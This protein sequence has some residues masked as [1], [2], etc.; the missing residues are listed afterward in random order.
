MTNNNKFYQFIIP[1]KDSNLLKFLNNINIIYKDDEAVLCIKNEDFSLD[2]NDDGITFNSIIN[3]LQDDL[4]GV[5]KFD[6]NVEKA[7]DYSEIEIPLGLYYMLSL[8][9]L[10]SKIIH[11]HEKKIFLSLI[12]R[13]IEILKQSLINNT[14][15]SQINNLFNMIIFCITNIVLQE[16]DILEDLINQNIKLFENKFHT[17]NKKNSKSK[18]RKNPKYNYEIDNSDSSNETETELDNSDSFHDQL[19][20]TDFEVNLNDESIQSNKFIQDSSVLEISFLLVKY[21]IN[22][23]KHYLNVN[24]S[25]VGLSEWSL[26]L[27]LRIINLVK[28]LV[29]NF[30]IETFNKLCKINIIKWENLS[31]NLIINILRS[32]NFIEKYEEKEEYHDLKS[33]L[34]EIISNCFIHGSIDLI[35]NINHIN[36]PNNRN[37]VIFKDFPSF[38]SASTMLISEEFSNSLFVYILENLGFYWIKMDKIEDIGEDNNIIVY[39]SSY[40]ESISINNPNIILKNIS[41]IRRILKVMISYKLRSCFISST[42]NSLIQVKNKN[43]IDPYCLSSSSQNIDNNYNKSTD[44]TLEK[45]SQIIESIDL[46]LER[47][48][49]K[50]YNCRTRSIQSIQRL[51]INDIIP[52]SFFITIFKEINMRTLDESSYVRSSSLNLL[53]TM[54]R[55]VTENYYHLPLNYEH[56]SNLLNNINLEL[57]HLNKNSID[58]L[59]N[60]IINSNIN[61]VETKPQELIDPNFIKKKESEYELM[62]VLL[63]DAKEVSIIVEDILEKVCINGI[64]SKINSDASSSILFICETVSLN[65]KKGQSL[66]SN[67]LKCIWRV[68]NVNILNSVVHG[69]FIIMFNNLSNFS[70]S[71]NQENYFQNELDNDDDQNLKLQ[72][73]EKIVINQ[74]TI[75]NLLKIIE[76]FNDDDMMNFSKLLEHLTSKNT[77]ISKKYTQNFDLTLLKSYTLNEISLVGSNLT[78]LNDEAENNLVSLLELLLVIIKVESLNNNCIFEIENKK[79]SNFEILYQLFMNSASNKNYIIFEYS[80]KC[81]NLIKIN[82]QVYTNEILSTYITILSNFDY[83]LINNSLLINIINSVFNLIA[84]PSNIK[85]LNT[86]ENNSKVLYIDFFINKL[87]AHFHKRLRKSKEVSIIELSQII[88]L[89]SHIVLKYGNFVENLYNKWKYLYSI[90]Q[91]SSSEKA[92]LFQEKN[93]E[94]GIINLEEEYFEYIQIILE[95]QLLSNDSIFYFIVPIINLLSRDPSLIVDYNNI[96]DSASDLQWQLDY[97]RN[98]AIVSLCKLTSLTTKLLNINEKMMNENSNQNLNINSKLSNLFEMPNIQLI[99]SFLYNP[100]SFNFINKI[101]MDNIMLNIILCTNDLLTRYPNIIDPWMEKQYSL[102]NLD[103]NSNETE[104]NSLKYNIMLIINYLLNIGFIKP[105]EILLLSY[106][107]CISNKSEFNSELSS[108]ANSFFQEFFK[109]LNNQLAINIIPLLINQLAL[110]Y[111]YNYTDKGKTQTIIHQTQYLLHY[112]NNKDNICS[113]LIPKFFFRISLLNDSKAIELYVIA[114]ESLKLGSKSRCISKIIENLNLITFH[115]QEF[116]FLKQYFAKILQNHINSNQID[117]NSEIF[118]LFKDESSRNVKSNPNLANDKTNHLIFGAENTPNN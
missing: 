56:I 40:V 73:N 59:N 103:D 44:F 48:Y 5:F 88:N 57:N 24:F 65:I 43:Q 89:L 10:W 39:I 105:K 92:K 6:L 95:N 3:Y 4:L 14:E 68:N 117:T 62:K 102:L 1:K 38:I 49:D 72:F 80:V 52:Y 61:D 87:F 108:L 100:S 74:S 36:N 45:R 66:L 8:S 55:K 17:N 28:K 31:Q 91:K 37:N 94:C 26:I 118:S 22:F 116:D 71:D 63:V 33:C 111:S 82:N 34:F 2:L 113:S 35:S 101:Q 67:V 27:S 93:S 96:T 18:R 16:F 114:F 83:K 69:F 90:V 50:H 60:T 78:N 15:K 20:N 32:I 81:L 107:K 21:L 13:Y 41:L 25:T 70:N 51:F 99:F 106:L 110:E 79:N 86:K 76:L 30:E 7:N 29:T 98:C 97:S 64:H 42:A 12:L 77:Q 115:I 85:F 54:V 109:D 75:K 112:I 84:N 46:L 47:I 19:Q 11:I 9:Y 58:D 23:S 53:R 104:I